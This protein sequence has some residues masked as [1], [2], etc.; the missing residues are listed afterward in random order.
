MHIRNTAIS[1]RNLD[2][3]RRVLDSE[4]LAGGRKRESAGM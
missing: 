1:E 2:F 3:S 4:G